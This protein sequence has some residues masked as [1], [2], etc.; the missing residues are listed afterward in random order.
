[1]LAETLATGTWTHDYP[2][3]A[4]AARALGL[5][6]STEMPATILELMQ[7]YPQT[8]QRRPSVEYIPTPYRSPDTG[9]GSR[10]KDQLERCPGLVGNITY[11]CGSPSDR[12]TEYAD[13]GDRPAKVLSPLIDSPIRPTPARA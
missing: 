7:L 3:T 8:S 2:I 10:H 11:I 12:L 6:V 13:H 9:Q 1:M 4:E 5:P